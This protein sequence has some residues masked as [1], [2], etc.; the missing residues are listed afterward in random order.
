[1]YSTYNKSLVD[2]EDI[3]R[4]VLRLTTTQIRLG[5]YD[6]PKTQIYRSYGVEHVN[7][8]FAENEARRIAEESFVL[9]KN[10]A[11]TLPL[12]LSKVKTVALIGP[13]LND[14]YYMQGNYRSVPK[15]P[16]T[17][18]AGLQNVEDITVSSAYGCSIN[19]N[20]K[21][22]FAAALALAKSAD[23]TIFVG[24]NSEQVESEGNDRETIDWPGVQ[25]DLI[26]QLET[27]AKTFVVLIT[28][29][30]Q[31]DCTYEKSSNTVDALLWIGYPAQAA[32]TA[33][34]NTLFGV[35]APAGRLPVT[36]Y[37]ADYVNQINMTDMGLR[38]TN[39][40]PGRTYKFYTGEPVYSFGYGLSYTTWSYSWG[41]PMLRTYSIEAIIKHS[42]LFAGPLPKAPFVSYVVNVTNT[43]Q[44]TSDHAVLL[45]V[46]SS[47]PDTPRAQLIDYTRIRRVA[48]GETR[49]I[50]F[51]PLLSSMATVDMDG[52]KMLEP[53]DYHLWIGNGREC[54]LGHKFSMTG[55]A[56]MIEKLPPP[57]P[58]MEQKAAGY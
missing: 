12:S 3:N 25:E 15:N 2:D 13:L 46:N 10:N 29:G 24:G 34:A 42:R 7:T 40:T 11:A 16:V 43:G 47:V 31:I 56:E 49:T 36:Q 38:A 9:L 28:G 41:A 19:G 21:S 35:T 20:D 58:T 1:M 5:F 53:A 48:P 17:L 52:N 50:Y 4:A 51:T 30:G 8:P 44:V 54:D 6:N 18:F 37:I 55:L 45:F 32:G 14:T 22:G 33:V 23:V 27:V 39:T 57:P 26:K